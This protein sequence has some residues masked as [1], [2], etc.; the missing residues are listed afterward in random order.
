MPA[1]TMPCERSDTE[2]EV[3]EKRTMTAKNNYDCDDSQHPTMW[4][5]YFI[6]LPMML[7]FHDGRQH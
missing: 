6:C 2:L 5:Y 1:G 4:F 7:N 3:E